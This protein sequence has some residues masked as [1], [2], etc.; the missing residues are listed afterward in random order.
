[1]GIFSCHSETLTAAAVRL[2]SV[3]KPSGTSCH[4]PYEGGIIFS[5]PLQ[6]RAGVSLFVVVN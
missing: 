3:G 5:R 4:L 1:M 2:R 6:V